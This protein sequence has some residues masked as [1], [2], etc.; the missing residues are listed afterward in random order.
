M[1]EPPTR[2][3]F[4]GGPNHEQFGKWEGPIPLIVMVEEPTGYKLDFSITDD[5][6]AVPIPA[7]Y[8]YCR[9]GTVV[10]GTRT[11]FEIYSCREED[12]RDAATI[13]GRPT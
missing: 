5:K 9:I 10:I 1:S 4:L 2:V 3:L 13:L 8:R 12:L 11:L 7:S 6:T